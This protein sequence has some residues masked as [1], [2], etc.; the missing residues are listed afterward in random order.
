VPGVSEH[1]FI[2]LTV[3]NTIRRLLR[4]CIQTFAT[5]PAVLAGF[6]ILSLPSLAAAPASRPPNI[7]IIL[8]DDLG[9]GDVGFNGCTD[10]PTPNLDRL[11]ADGTIFR[12]GYAT[13]PY[14]SPS[15]AG[16]MSGRY[17]QRLGHECNTPYEHDDPEAGLPLDQPILSE[18][19]HNEGYRTAMIGKW[20]LGDFPKFWPNR[21]GFDEWYGI[22]GGGLDYWGDT[23]DKPPIAGVL[24]N[25][26][27][28]PR[29]EITYLTDN[30][31][32]E[33]IRFIDRNADRPFFLYLA[34]NAPHA[35]I[36]APARYLAMTEHIEDGA[37]AAYA[38][39]VVGMDIGIGR[40][41]D[42][43][44][45]E[46]LYENTLVVF[47]SDNGGHLHG[48]SNAPFRGN[49]GMLFEGGIRVPFVISWPQRFHR[50]VVCEEPI[51]ALDIFPTALAAAGIPVPGGLDLEG[52]DLTPYLTGRTSAPPS[53]TLFWRVSGGAG[54]AVRQGDYKLVHSIFKPAPLLFDLRAD[55]FEHHNLAEAMP[56]KCRELEALY[57]AWNAANIPPKWDDPHFANRDIQVRERQ[58]HIDRAMAGEKTTRTAP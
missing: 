35:P 11:A 54:W 36:Q 39:M 2:S 32:D 14:C 21:R 30:F 3:M 50:G 17:Q 38:A 42:K 12:A 31:T 8:A 51:I 13:H 4:P 28:A 22:Y 7:I 44:R 41:L 53:R 48:A 26:E 24:R 27:I 52:I 9:W 23:G 57:N 5:L 55:P 46:D 6:A 40:V 34:Y 29:E 10:I 1:A 45:R 58:R 33:A 16:L 37:R 43:L 15:R 56:E 20:H 47:Y 25:G 49:K 19:L 18:I